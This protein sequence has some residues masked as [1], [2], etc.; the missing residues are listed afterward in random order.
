MQNQ[1]IRLTAESPDLFP[2]LKFP[3]FDFNQAIQ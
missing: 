2:A 1:G 3:I